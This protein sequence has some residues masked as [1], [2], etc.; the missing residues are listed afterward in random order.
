MIVSRLEKRLAHVVRI[1]FV[2]L[3]CAS[4]ALAQ[5]APSS[6][7]HAW[8]GSGEKQIEADARRLAESRVTIELGKTYSLVELIDFAETHNPETRFGWERA[9]SQAAALGI[10]RSELYPTLAAAALSQTRRYEILVGDRFVR[11]TVQDFDTA[12]S[13]NYTVFD[14]GARSARISAAR[15]EVLAAN[16]AFNDT[17]RKVI[18]QVEEAYYRLL[19][20]IGQEDAA[21]ANLSNARKVQQAAEERLAN[22]LATLPD[23]LEA[24]S[25]TAQSGYELQAVLGNE[26]I[27]RGDLA[28]ALG[29][30]AGTVIHVQTLDQIPTPDSVGD[31]VDQAIVRALRQRPDL[32]EQVAQIRSANARIKEAHSAYYPDLTLNAIPAAQSSYGLQQQVPWAHTSGLLGGIV[33][34]LQWTIFD[35]GLRKNRLAQAR[36]DAKA[37]E[38][39]AEAAHDQIADQVWAAYSNLNTALRER[40]AATAL[41][42]AASQSY[43][44]ALESY[45]YGL[46]NLLDV[47]AA[48]RILAQA[49]A[50][51]VLARTQVLSARASLA[52]QTGDL[53]QQNAA[54]P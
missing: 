17:H 52:S 25:A 20:S 23:V 33:F 14:F 54:R 38:A 1:L 49:R 22:G 42:E 35:G 53:I 5:S 15:A 21:Q 34:N 50:A 29:I 7:D 47:T 46:R 26:E 16:F 11:Q 30:S 40:E 8:H 24:R 48:Q 10:A 32:L 45:K 13:L 36:A 9:R 51:E 18:Y 6:S 43:D 31:S 4:C 3:P 27:A 28:T 2:F 19:N 44:A 12:L 39:Q 41:L 37:A